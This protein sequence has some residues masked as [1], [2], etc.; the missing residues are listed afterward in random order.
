M[1]VPVPGY[2]LTLPAVPSAATALGDARRRGPAGVGR[3]PS[4]R[5]P[6]READVGTLDRARRGD[7][8]ALAALL[9]AFQ[10][11]WY[12]FSLSL[13]RDPDAA[14]DAVQEIGL[15]FISR[16]EGFRGDSQLRTWSL[17]IAVN[18][19]R[20]MRR[21]K[22]RDRDRGGEGHSA[23]EDDAP[24]SD[25]GSV[26]AA[27]ELS[28]QR[29]ALRAVM[30]DLPDRQREAIALRF[31]EDLSVDETARAMGCAQGTVKATVHQALRSLRTRLQRWT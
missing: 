25:R 10:D 21:R 11:P 24:A 27:A 9:T 26:E 23:D 17:G 31:F 2:S 15:R 4:A 14:A 8:T 1:A 6:T 16:L 20:E 22:A 18:V 3:P 7:R 12:R 5:E 13:L 30:A 28:E 29:G 19:V